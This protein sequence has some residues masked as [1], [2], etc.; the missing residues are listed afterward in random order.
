MIRPEQHYI[1]ESITDTIEQIE[2]DGLFTNISNYMAVY[3]YKLVS[4]AQ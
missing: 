3:H 1:G 2:Y 4:Y